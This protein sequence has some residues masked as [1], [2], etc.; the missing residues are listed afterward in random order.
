MTAVSVEDRGV[1]FTLRS[2]YDSQDNRDRQPAQDDGHRQ[3]A[4]HARDERRALGYRQGLCQRFVV[5]AHAAF[6]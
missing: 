3:Q 4:D 2:A 6:N 1:A 5:G